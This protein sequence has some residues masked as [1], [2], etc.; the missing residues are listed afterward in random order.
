MK[1][2]IFWAVLVILVLGGCGAP[3]QTEVPTH[4]TEGAPTIVPSET[5]EISE[6]EKREELVIEDG[7]LYVAII[8]HQHQPVYFKDPNT[9]IYEKPWVRLHSAKDYVDMAAIL[10]EYPQIHA[11]FNITP[12][13]IRQLDD[14]STGAKDLYWV[15]TEIPAEELTTE[16]RQF[17]LDWHEMA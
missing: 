16:Q 7:K 5:E 15:Y 2:W 11:T 14:I 10:E 9:G 1:R 13:L 8:W 3:K 6:S 4:P 12:S 17:I